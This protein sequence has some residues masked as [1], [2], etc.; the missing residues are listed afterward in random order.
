MDGWM[1]GWDMTGA[2]PAKWHTLF[3][4]FFFSF[5]FL[6]FSFCESNLCRR[7]RLQLEPHLA[8][9]SLFFFFFFF[10]R[11]RSVRGA[12]DWNSYPVL[13]R[14]CVVWCCCFPSSPAWNLFFPFCFLSLWKEKLKYT[15]LRQTS[16]RNWQFILIAISLMFSLSSF[17]HCFFSHAVPCRAVPCRAFR[18]LVPVPAHIVFIW[19]RPT[20]TTGAVARGESSLSL[21]LLVLP[22]LPLLNTDDTLRPL[23]A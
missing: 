20:G 12:T 17:F 23:N 9:S 22:L 14:Y 2:R 15:S 10:L 11:H 6:F 3:V 21:L 8:S 7:R 1:D 18:L 5:S 19:G 16:E 13:C 4:S